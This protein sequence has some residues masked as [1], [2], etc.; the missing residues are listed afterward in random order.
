MTF[1]GMYSNDGANRFRSTPCILSENFYIST[2]LIVHIFLSCWTLK[3]ALIWCLCIAHGL[4][5]QIVRNWNEQVQK[6]W[7]ASTSDDD[8]DDDDNT[9]VMLRTLTLIF[10]YVMDHNCNPVSRFMMY[11]TNHSSSHGI[12]DFFLQYVLFVYTFI[13]HICIFASK[14]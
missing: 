3:T 1:L 8:N 4:H 2:S 10:S 6:K 9:S 11:P 7:W 5:Q 12:L 13:I 14:L